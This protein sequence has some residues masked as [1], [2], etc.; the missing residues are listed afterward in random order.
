MNFH[1][2]ITRSTQQYWRKTGK[3]KKNFKIT[4]RS[5]SPVERRNWSKYKCLNHFVGA[6]LG[7]WGGRGT[8]ENKR[9]ERCGTMLSSALLYLTLLHGELQ[10]ERPY[11]TREMS[12][13][14]LQ[15]QSS[16]WSISAGL[17]RHLLCI[18]ALVKG[19]P[20]ECITSYC[21]DLFRITFLSSL[22]SAKGLH[23]TNKMVPL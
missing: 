8:K 1:P 15:R 3:L 6:S 19:E 14:A 4:C 21:F 16:S 5:R 2:I 12:P 11:S 13:N 10:R 23:L 7:Q 9:K 20:V 17:L 18:L 22:S